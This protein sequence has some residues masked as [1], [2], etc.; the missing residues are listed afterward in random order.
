MFGKAVA[1]AVE[2]GRAMTKYFVDGWAT[3]GFTPDEKIT[4]VCVRGE[5][6]VDFRMSDSW[7]ITK[8]SVTENRREMVLTV[9]KG[10]EE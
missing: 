9:E 10:E 6:V 7:H 3:V 1:G 5:E 2:G 8:V 4:R